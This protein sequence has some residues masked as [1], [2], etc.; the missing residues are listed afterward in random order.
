M[1]IITE[2][3]TGLSTAETYASVSFADT[4]FSDRGNTAWAALTTSVKEASLRKSTEYMLQVYRNRWIG[5]RYTTVQALDWPRW[6]VAV[7][8][9]QT[10]IETNQIP[11]DVKRACAELASRASTATLYADETR[12]VVIESV[13]PL[14]VEYDKYSGQAIRY[15]AIDSM[16]TI[17]FSSA[18]GQFEVVRR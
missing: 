16:L 2:D 14:S 13:G 4:Y 18:S 1:S 10:V 15:K 9:G 17:Y 11:I 6:G 12:S 7:D 8:G 3:G 5:S